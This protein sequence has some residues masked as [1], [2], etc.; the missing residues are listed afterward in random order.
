ME[1]ISQITT[2]KA[3]SLYTTNDEQYLVMEFRDDTSAFDGKKTAALENKGKVNN[4]FNAFIMEF[5][6]TKEINTHF[7]KLLSNNESL[8][9][10][11]D[12]FPIE[13]VVRNRATGSLCKRLGIEDGYILETP[14][15]EFFLK[16]DDLGDPLINDNHIISFGWATKEELGVMQSITLKVN[17]ILVDFFSEANLLLIDFKLEFGKFKDQIML[18]DEF[19]PDGCR[20]WDKD[21]LNKMDKDRFRQDLGN[22]IE[23]YGEVADRLGMQ[24]KLD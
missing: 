14:L 1:K 18:G 3:K 23:T 4:Q 12:M 16:D 13:C 8:V 7:I 9:R 10:N 5:L 24:I 11:L 20:L 17:E 15:F 6:S 2:G 22:V 21:T 19:T